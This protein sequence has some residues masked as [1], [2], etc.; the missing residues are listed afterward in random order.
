[1]KKVLRKFN[2]SGDTKSVSTLLAPHFKLKVTMSPTTVEEHGYISHVPYATVDSLMYAIV[3][4]R[5]K[6][7]Q[8]ILMVSIM[9][10]QRYHR[11]WF[12]VRDGYYG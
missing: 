1:L 11:C 7:S 9:A 10:H 8:A 12:G 3:C 4:T 5:P 6:S 2:I